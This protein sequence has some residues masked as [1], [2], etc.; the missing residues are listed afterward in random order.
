MSQVKIKHDAM[1][2][3]YYEIEGRITLHAA[4]AMG[5]LKLYKVVGEN[6]AYIADLFGN[7][8]MQIDFNSASN[9]DLSVRAV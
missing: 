6:T 8:L 3:P 4:P 7:V 2:R 1:G 9:V 5:G